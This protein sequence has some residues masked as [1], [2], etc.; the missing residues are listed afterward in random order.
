[1]TVAAHPFPSNSVQS[2][3]RD[4]VV[5]R[6]GELLTT[7]GSATA[8]TDTYRAA[9]IDI[10]SMSGPHLPPRTPPTR[11]IIWTFTKPTRLLRGTSGTRGLFCVGLASRRAGERTRGTRVGVAQRAA[12]R[13]AWTQRMTGGARGRPDTSLE[14]GPFRVE[15]DDARKNAS[16]QHT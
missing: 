2:R 13:P 9:T 4:P 6:K 3:P 16:A 15:N 11:L 10:A 1:M 5:L 14:L 12:A 7:R 8:A